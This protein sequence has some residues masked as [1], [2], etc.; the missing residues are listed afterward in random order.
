MLELKERSFDVLVAS[1]SASV[2]AD[3]LSGTVHA[4]VSQT[5]SVLSS[6]SDPGSGSGK[7]RGRGCCD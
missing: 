4:V 6:E 3:A 2:D 5:S 7:G 1:S